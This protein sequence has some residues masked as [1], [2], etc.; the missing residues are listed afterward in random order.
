MNTTPPNTDSGAQVK[1]AAGT[2]KDTGSTE[3]ASRDGGFDKVINRV[4]E[5]KTA[6]QRKSRA[7]E[8]SS[9]SSELRHKQ[10]G[11]GAQETGHTLKHLLNASVVNEA[12]GEVLGND[13]A[14]G[15]RLLA[16]TKT[17]DQAMKMQL[18]LLTDLA[19]M[20][21]TASG[22]GGT[23]AQVLNSLS[24]NQLSSVMG[25]G[26]PKPVSS[27]NTQGL[28]NSS[29]VKGDS[30]K[31]AQLEP[32]LEGSRAIN[33]PKG[34]GESVGVKPP[35]GDL[36]HTK[37]ASQSSTPAV[38]GEVKVVS[39]ETHLAPAEIGRP[40]QQVA[41]VLAKQMPSAAKAAQELALQMG[42]QQPAKPMKSLQI[43]LRPDN[44]G[45]VRANIQMRGGELEIT[46][47]TS[48]PEAADMLKGDR[49]ALARVLQDA[50]YRTETQNITI[51]FKEEMSDQMRQPGQNQERFGRGANAEGESGEET[52]QHSWEDQADAEYSG[53]AQNESDTQ[54]LRSGIYL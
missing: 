1:N 31:V 8:E 41:S 32:K 39:V 35:A 9:E 18:G 20:A 45:M 15:D 16:G 37:S 46:L 22:R 34:E 14:N 19:N 47:T 38:G 28:A 48:T 12:Q 23:M 51:S 42:E 29:T 27:K 17:S 21:G 24:V 50:G 25:E 44:M 11:K 54:D 53:A 36:L 43:Q 30:L 33:F 10:S 49:Q 7:D 2:R 52:A 13:G 6:P 4:Q 26:E 5:Q 3:E 40:A